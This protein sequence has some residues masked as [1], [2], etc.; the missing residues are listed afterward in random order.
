MWSPEEDAVL[1]G[2]NAR[3]IMLLEKKHGDVLD[4][5]DW[6]RRYDAA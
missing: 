1:M 2:N 6:L 3:A 5:A 4:R